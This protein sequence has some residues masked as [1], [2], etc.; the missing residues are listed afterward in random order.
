MVS[1]ANTA[2][3]LPMIKTHNENGR[4]HTHNYLNISQ[5]IMIIMKACTSPFIENIFCIHV[6]CTLSHSSP[7]HPRHGGNA[8]NAVDIH[9][10]VARARPELACR[11]EVGLPRGGRPA[12]GGACVAVQG[13]WWRMWKSKPPGGPRRARRQVAVGGSTFPAVSILVPILFLLLSFYTFACRDVM[14]S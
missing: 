13:M 14:F 6:T 3:S 12:A 4:A 10:G 11:G 7:L 1:V 8:G 9:L 2:S 5:S